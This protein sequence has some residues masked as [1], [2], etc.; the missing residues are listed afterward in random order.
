MMPQPLIDTQIL[1]AF[2]GARSPGFAMVEEY[3]GLRW[4]KANPAPTGW[5]AR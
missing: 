2:S 3:T 5:R 4:I 1:A